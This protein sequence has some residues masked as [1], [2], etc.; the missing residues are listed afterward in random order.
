MAVIMQELMQGMSDGFGIRLIAGESG[1]FKSAEWIYAAEDIGNAD[2]LKAGQLIITT[3]YFKNSGISLESFISTMICKRAAGMIVNTGKYIRETEITAE[4][5]ELCDRQAFA[6][7]TMPW[8]AHI[9]DVTQMLCGRIF[10]RERE[11]HNIAMGIKGILFMPER[12][13]SYLAELES[14]GFDTERKRRIVCLSMHADENRCAAIMSGYGIRHYVFECRGET[15]MICDENERIGR[16]V[17]ELCEKLRVTAGVSMAMDGAQ[18]IAAMYE[19]AQTA[20]SAANIEAVRMLEYEKT[21]ALA[22]IFAVKDKTLLRNMYK[23]RLSE[24]ERYDEEHGGELVNTLFCYLREGASPAETA[25]R[26]YIHRNTIGYRM[27]K[28]RE[29]C[30]KSFEDAQD[31]YDYLTAL[32]IK[33]ALESEDK[34]KERG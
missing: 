20:K 26:M 4:I 7:Y 11:I 16:A 17:S 21:G 10:E 23:S 12:T 6:L 19:Q 29:I 32:Y 24:L 13:E 15:L 1:V 8:E 25:K 9:A 2:F 3:G 27:N 18:H 28:I 31:R 5:K 22:L 34:R 14:A 30:G 33:K